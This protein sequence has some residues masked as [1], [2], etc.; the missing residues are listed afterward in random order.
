MLIFLL[1][2]NKATTN[3]LFHNYCFTL[4][5]LVFFSYPLL[6]ASDNKTAITTS[7]PFP[8]SS[9]PFPHRHFPSTPIVLLSCNNNQQQQQQQQTL[10]DIVRK[11]WSSTFRVKETNDKIF[12]AC[13][14]LSQVPFARVRY[15]RRRK[16]FTLTNSNKCRLRRSTTLEQAS[17]ILV[18]L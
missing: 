14:T 8:P 15:F 10:S 3:S 12:F 13:P 17:H 18:G 7:F 9:L 16:K 4:Q 6:R 2:L 1:K 5:G 11:T